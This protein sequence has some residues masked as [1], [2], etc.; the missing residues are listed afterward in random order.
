MQTNYR[1]FRLDK[2]L[3]TAMVNKFDKSRT[4][5]FLALAA[6]IAGFVPLG[7]QADESS[8][9]SVQ[10]KYS[11]TSLNS[12][13]GARHLY[14]RIYRA[15]NYACGTSDLDMDVMVRF[16]PGPCVKATVARAVRQLN[17]AKLTQVYIEKNGV[18]VASTFGIQRDTRTAGN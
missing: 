2:S 3:E 9:A 7:S 8:P 1:L 15:A 17:S 11:S 16:G 13:E 10:L 12:T 18:D 14:A 4:R 5:A 6:V